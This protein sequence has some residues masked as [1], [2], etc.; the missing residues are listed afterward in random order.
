MAQKNRTGTMTATADMVSDGEAKR[1]VALLRPAISV[2]KAAEAS[3]QPPAIHRMDSA[4]AN[5]KG[6]EVGRRCRA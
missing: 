3:H 2:E 6:A 1:S 5:Q 4:K